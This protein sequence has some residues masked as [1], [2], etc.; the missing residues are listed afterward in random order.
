M[1]TGHVCGP[2]A[3]GHQFLAMGRHQAASMSCMSSHSLTAAVCHPVETAHERSA[4]AGAEGPGKL[5]EQVAQIDAF[6]GDS[7][8]TDA[9][10]RT[11]KVVPW[12]R[13]LR[14]SEFRPAL[15]MALQDMLAPTASGQLKP[16]APLQVDLQN[17]GKRMPCSG[18]TIK[19][20]VYLCTWPR[21]RDGGR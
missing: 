11:S 14:R 13:W 16:S 19:R 9:V 10:P 7:C 6:H 3:D 18:Q 8:F 15:Q 21:L 4:L 12:I 17:L 5:R 1:V 20:L 2:F